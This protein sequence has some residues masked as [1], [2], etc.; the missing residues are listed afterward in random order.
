MTFL[1]YFQITTHDFSVKLNVGMKHANFHFF[2]DDESRLKTAFTAN[3]GHYEYTRIVMGL[4][5]SA[6]TWQS[7]LMKVLSDMVFEDAV[8]RRYFNRAAWNANAVLR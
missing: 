8:P 2:L 7:L 4:C 6:Q 1:T 3:G 5:N